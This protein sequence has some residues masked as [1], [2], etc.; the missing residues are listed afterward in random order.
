MFSDSKDMS[1][2]DK[3]TV[4]AAWI[5][6]VNSGFKRSQFTKALYRHLT[7]HCSFIA[8]YNLDC[9]YNLYFTNSDLMDRF[10]NQFLTGYAAEGCFSTMWIK[11]GNDYCEQFYDINNAMVR[12]AQSV[13]DKMMVGV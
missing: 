8:H 10:T 5:R 1:A 4:Y 6:F 7:L 2:A 9:F 12:Y 11:G 13:E 3:A